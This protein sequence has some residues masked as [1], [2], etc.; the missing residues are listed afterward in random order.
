VFYLS[1]AIAFVSPWIGFALGEYLY[2]STQMWAHHSCEA[3]EFAC[4]QIDFLSF[5]IKGIIAGAVVGSLTKHKA[6]LLVSCSSLVTLLAFLHFRLVYIFGWHTVMYI[7]FQLRLTIPLLLF[8][9]TGYYGLSL[10]R[11]RF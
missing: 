1:I 7:E 2:P 3:T 5:G 11:A 9:A 10:V 4:L 6:I 8:F